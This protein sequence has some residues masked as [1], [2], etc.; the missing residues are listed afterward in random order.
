M[1][2][3]FSAKLASESSS[4]AK[5]GVDLVTEWM[6]QLTVLGGRWAPRRAAAVVARSTPTPSLTSQG[7]SGSEERVHIEMASR[8]WTLFVIHAEFTV[9]PTASLGLWRMR[10]KSKKG[11]RCAHRITVASVCRRRESDKY[12]RHKHS[13]KMLTDFPPPDLIQTNKMWI[14]SV[15]DAFKN[16]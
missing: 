10:R 8:F 15:M 5:C 9:A 14:G 1:Q 12:W 2:V 3:L 7:E 13:K 16:L 11:T 4:R 6:V